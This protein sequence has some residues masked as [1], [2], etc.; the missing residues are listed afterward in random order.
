M[1]ARVGF[2]R[3]CSLSHKKASIR[4]NGKEL[5]L[6]SENPPVSSTNKA[7]RHDIIEMLLKMALNTIKQT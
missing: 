6:L 3:S 2:E 5:S 1:H 4:S 7:D